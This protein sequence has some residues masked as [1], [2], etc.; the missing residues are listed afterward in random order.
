MGEIASTLSFIFLVADYQELPGDFPA[1]HNKTP[2][3]DEV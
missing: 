1:L 2:V 3:S